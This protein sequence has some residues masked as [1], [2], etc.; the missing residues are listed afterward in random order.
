MVKHRFKR[1][2]DI[3]EEVVARIGFETDVS[4]T[5]SVP[6]NCF[7]IPPATEDCPDDSQPMI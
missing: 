1:R 7:Q 4:D 3:A 6:L 5:S 2:E